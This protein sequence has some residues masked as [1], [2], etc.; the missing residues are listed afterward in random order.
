MLNIHPSLLPAFPGL[1]THR[2]VLEAGVNE[3]GASVHFVTAA[4]D[5]GPVIAQAR[6]PVQS[7][8]TPDSLAARVLGQE[9]RLYPL[10][11]LWYALGRIREDS[12]GRVLFDGA[13]L[14]A[15]VDMAG[16][17]DLPC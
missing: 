10:A 9:H 2:R 1:D 5:G 13:P 11:I 16:I 4:T 7:G 14:S 17:D 8:D 15:P 12:N 3:H 6:V